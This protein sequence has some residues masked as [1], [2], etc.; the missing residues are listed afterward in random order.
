MLC[1][2]EKMIPILFWIGFFALGIAT[3]LNGQSKVYS[4]RGPQ[5]ADMEAAAHDVAK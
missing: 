3:S 1:N 4:K 2:F 5:I